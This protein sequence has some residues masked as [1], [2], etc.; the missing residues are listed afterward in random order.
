MAVSVNDL[1]DQLREY[2]QGKPKLTMT[3]LRRS[4]DLRPVAA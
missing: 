2:Y 1:L 3:G 4:L